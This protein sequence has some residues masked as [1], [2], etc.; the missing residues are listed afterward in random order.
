MCP[1]MQ[2]SSNASGDVEP[3]RGS[4]VESQYLRSALNVTQL[5]LR[6]KQA[7][8]GET[9]SLV[10]LLMMAELEMRWSQ[11]HEPDGLPTPAEIRAL[12][13]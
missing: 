10:L 13:N 12:I 5:A 4:T 7:P 1:M 6:S 9:A 3:A 11:L 2:T 8:I